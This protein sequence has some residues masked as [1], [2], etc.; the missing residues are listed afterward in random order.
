M[1]STLAIFSKHSKYLDPLASLVSSLIL[2][3]S[4]NVNEL[5]RGQLAPPHHFAATKPSFYLQLTA[6]DLFQKRSFQEAGAKLRRFLFEANFLKNFFEKSRLFRR[7]VG[8]PAKSGANIMRFR[9]FASDG[10][11]FSGKFCLL[12]GIVYRRSFIVYANDR[13]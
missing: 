2:I 6:F 7:P 3:L 5:F 9:I 11:I 8:R 10:G 13:R 1:L 12:E 4:Q